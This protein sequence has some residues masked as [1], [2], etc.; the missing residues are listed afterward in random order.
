MKYKII[1]TLLICARLISNV[2]AQTPNLISYQAVIRNASGALVSSKTVKARISI[3]KDSANGTA[4][5]TEAHQVK[6][7]ANGLMSLQIG[8]GS[9][10]SGNFN[11]IDWGKTNYFTKQEIDPDGGTNYTLS[12][13][14]QMLSVPYALH[15]KNAEKCF[16]HYVGELYGG[17]VVFHV[18]KDTA[19]VEHGLVVNKYWLGKG[20]DIRVSNPDPWG[21]NY[22]NIDFSWFDG[23]AN[24]I[25]IANATNHIES[26]ADFCLK[27]TE[28]GY[29]DWYL[30]SPYEIYLL[31]QH[32]FNVDQ[33]LKAKGYDL[34]MGELNLLTS[35][36]AG[37]TS[38]F[39]WNVFSYL[40]T[41]R[42][43]EIQSVPSESPYP[44]R[45]IRK[46]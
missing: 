35:M 19:G 13:V 15:A 24:S 12:G 36:A 22:E 44:F 7:N 31:Q 34:V 39:A 40:P 37:E 11:T 38:F 33:T 43:Q 30:G 41:F 18:W 4:V 9:I 16:Q 1:I 6:T 32:L 23:H 28:G 10:V 29:D 21:F 3:L 2:A 5:Y 42:N 17:G 46:F 25:A 45:A 14:S 8:G 27:L 20:N 26:A